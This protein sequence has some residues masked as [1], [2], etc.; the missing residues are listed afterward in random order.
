MPMAPNDKVRVYFERLVS[1]AQTPEGAEAMHHADALNSKISALL[2]HV[3]LM[4]A[5]STGFFIWT[6]SPRANLGA[7]GVSLF[8]EIVGYVLI[9]ALCL[10]GIWITGYRTFQKTKA[11]PV[12]VFFKI[13][14]ATWRRIPSPI[15]EMTGAAHPLEVYPAAL[16]MP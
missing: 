2:T 9:S 8:A 11:E 10:R 12:D 6:A 5:I 4:I 3:S 16:A 7:I 14:R 15:S 1:V 13:V